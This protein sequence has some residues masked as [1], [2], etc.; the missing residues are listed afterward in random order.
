[1]KV[2]ERGRNVTGRWQRGAG[3]WDERGRK[4]AGKRQEVERKVAGR[5][6]EGN[7]IKLGKG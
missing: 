6:Q 5:W 7:M 1:M 4:A 3:R 2:A